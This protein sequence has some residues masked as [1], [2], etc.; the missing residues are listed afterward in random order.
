MIIYLSGCRDTLR[1]DA[2]S[3]SLLR[4]GWVEGVAP[5]RAQHCDVST[6][7]SGP[8]RGLKGAV[9]RRVEHHRARPYV[10]HRGQ[11]GR[12]GPAALGDQGRRLQAGCST[13]H[14][15][16]DGQ[17][18]RRQAQR[19]QRHGGG[20]GGPPGLIA[21]RS[22]LG[23]RYSPTSRAGQCD[24]LEVFRAGL[25]LAHPA[26]S[27]AVPGGPLPV[28]PLP[29]PPLLAAPS[30]PRPS[31]PRPSPSRPRPAEAARSTVTVPIRLRR[32][33]RLS[34][35]SRRPA[36]VATEPAIGTRPSRWASSPPTVSTSSASLRTPNS[37]ASSSTG[38]RAV[39]PARPSP[40]HSTGGCSLSYSS[41]ISPTISSRMSSMVTSPAVPPYSSITIAR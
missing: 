2:R 29:P 11:V 24:D 30:P 5:P 39:T 17:A 40:S 36:T 19:R 41:A 6:G 16:S 26:E 38:S 20:G 8:Q 9:G 22:A 3:R 23:R 28:R 25:G 1:P 33:A 32:P 15:H 4:G 27:S 18:Q 21:H 13:G 12:V 7:G 37:S 10:T 31:S 34:A 14:R 35:V